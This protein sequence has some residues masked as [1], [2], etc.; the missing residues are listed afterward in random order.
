MAEVMQD[1]N[2][3]KGGGTG[4]ESRGQTHPKT[5]TDMVQHHARSNRERRKGTSQLHPKHSYRTNDETHLWSMHSNAGC[6]HSMPA[7]T[8]AM[9]LLVERAQLKVKLVGL[10]QRQDRAPQH[11]L[12]FAGSASTPNVV[13]QD[14]ALPEL[15]QADWATGSRHISTYNIFDAMV[16]KQM[17]GHLL[18]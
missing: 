12:P 15:F 9:L 11:H 4:C 10:R 6:F 8:A 13:E 18:V 5:C 7:K 3:C 16:L 1:S 2:S 14:L 17:Q